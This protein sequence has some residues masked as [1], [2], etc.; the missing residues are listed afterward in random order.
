MLNGVPTYLPTYQGS[1][2]ENNTN[3]IGTIIHFNDNATLFP[4]ELFLIDLR[5]LTWPGPLMTFV[6]KFALLSF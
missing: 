5:V 3:V 6:H 2:K 1:S 4:L